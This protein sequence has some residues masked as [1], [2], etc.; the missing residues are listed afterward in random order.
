M[1]HG[2]AQ[3]VFH[4]KGNSSGRLLP[5]FYSHSGSVCQPQPGEKEVE[6]VDRAVRACGEEEK[7]DGGAPISAD[8]S[9]TDG[10]PLL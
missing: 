9:L 3:T 7:G 2:C 10:L 6:R 1:R 4:S 8:A 5:A